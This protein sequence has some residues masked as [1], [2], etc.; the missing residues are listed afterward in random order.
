MRRPTKY[1]SLTRPKLRQ[2][3]NKYNLFNI[4]RA[5]GR[6]PQVN[7]RA[8]FFQQ[9]WAAKS[10]TRGYHGEHVSEKKWVRL[11]SR[12]LQSAVDLPPEYLAANDG[13]E[14]AAGRG[15][16]LTTSNVTAETYSRVPKGSTTVRSP[17]H[18][19]QRGRA[20]GNVND[21]LSEH[22]QNMTPY[23]QMTFA[24][25][26][27]RLDTAVFRAMFAS[28]VRQAR[29][30][31]IHGAVKVN[32][33]KMVHPSYALNPGDMFQVEVEKVLYGTGEQKTAEYT[34]M[35]S[36][37]K[38]MLDQQEESV[39]KHGLKKQSKVLDAVAKEGE[40]A[41]SADAKALGKN[42]RRRV[43]RE[44]QLHRVKNLR[45]TAREI[46]KG[47]MRNLSAKQKKDLRLFRDT[48]QRFLS[49]PEARELDARDLLHQIQAQIT[50]LESVDTFRKAD[51]TL[52]K[53]ANAEASAEASAE[54]SAEPQTEKSVS[55]LSKEE[56]E[57]KK[58]QFKNNV[59]E[60]G[61]EGITNKADRDRA[62]NILATEN[63]T[64]EETRRLINIL[65]NDSENPIDP[66]KPY[67]TPW[68]PR[69]FMSAFAFI[70]R[71]LEVNPNICAAVYLRHPV[72]RKG[73][74]EV[75]TPFSYLTN[76]LAHN[77]YLGRG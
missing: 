66:S 34:T 35:E 65:R 21:M 18:P 14:Q 20:F 74:A 51:S 39:R 55:K 44:V 54:E 15:S 71:Y 69:P 33:K 31:I 43:E 32:G 1:Y 22:F 70:P 41:E 30:F 37:E 40:E 27:R 23:M 3:W 50:K 7:S 77:W 25:L 45:T 67:V 36:R 56:R 9:K 12:R 62:M 48:A 59:L 73:M 5:A 49:L 63:L 16:G 11:F 17:S 58:L 42:A 53:A 10:K 6:E 13:A 75:P 2:S 46:L 60:K 29:Q 64:H 28:S 26:E 68:R 52:A 76:Q 4:A 72:A 38:E 61:L 19:A 47:D 8:T 57:A 24:P